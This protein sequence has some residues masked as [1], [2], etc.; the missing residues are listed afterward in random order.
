[1]G[2]D[3]LGGQG[4][5]EIP[6]VQHTAQGS[7]HDR[8]QNCMCLAF[9]TLASKMKQIDTVQC[10]NCRCYSRPRNKPDRCERVVRSPIDGA[11]PALGS[12]C[13]SGHIHQSHIIDRASAADF[14]GL[15]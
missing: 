6:Y 7:W 3:I 12:R 15:S 4:G 5:A 14:Q 9:R 1:M 13:W 10:I 2:M 8:L 11:A